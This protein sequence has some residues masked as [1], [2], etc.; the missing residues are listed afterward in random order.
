MD[1]SLYDVDDVM[2]S[3]SV[4]SS[5]RSVASMRALH[6][7]AQLAALQKKNL[8]QPLEAARLTVEFQLKQFDLE[9][10]M[11]ITKAELDVY[12]NVEGDPEVTFRKLIAQNA[13]T[14]CEVGLD[15]P[16]CCTADAQTKSIFQLI[17]LA[18]RTNIL[19]RKIGHNNCI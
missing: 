10:Q 18:Q 2:S 6:K 7:R 16:K 4:A 15:Q 19:T 1:T 5:V 12:E 8:Q 17:Q 13:V 3:V 9:K 14:S 11:A